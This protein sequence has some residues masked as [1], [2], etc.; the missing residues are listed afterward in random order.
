MVKSQLLQTS[1]LAL[2]RKLL[3]YRDIDMPFA[4]ATLSALPYNHMVRELRLAM[5]SIQ[6]DFSRLQTVALVGEELAQLWDMEE[7]LLMFQALQHN[8]KWWHI[9]TSIG[10]KVDQRAFQGGDAMQRERCFIILY[11]TTSYT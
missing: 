10:V 2:S 3:V 1:L 6:S 9:L 11:N 8:A 4:V 5:P 7:L